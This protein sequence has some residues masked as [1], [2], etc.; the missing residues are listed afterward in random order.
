MKTLVLKPLSTKQ[1]ES[2][3]GGFFNGFALKST[4]TNSSQSTGF[5]GLGLI[6]IGRI[7]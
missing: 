7:L 3:S 4:G 2:V 5:V 6:G 1:S